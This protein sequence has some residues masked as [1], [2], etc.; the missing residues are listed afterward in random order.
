MTLP[1]AGTNLVAGAIILGLLGIVECFFG[2][3]FFRLVLAVIGFFIG[4]GFAIALVNSDQALIN[5]LVGLVGGVIGATLF[6]YLYFIGTFLAGIALGGTVAAV[7]AANLNLTSNVTNI[8]VI[9]GAVIGGILGI[10]FSKYIIMLSTAFTGA[11]Q[12]I[13]ALLLLLPGLRFVQ[14]ANQVEFR[15]DQPQTLIVTLVILILA[16]IGFA[17]QYNT[18]RH[19]VVVTTHQSPV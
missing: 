4:A 10:I 11:T 7:L 18:N 3:R 15:L 1:I 13:Y 12:I 6:Y 16:A 19:T 14:R 2:Y 8:V 9:V 17:V 5:A